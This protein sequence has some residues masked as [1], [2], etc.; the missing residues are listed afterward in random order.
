VLVVGLDNAGKTT[1][2]THLKPSKGDVTEVVPT[3]GFTVEEFGQNSLK[4][5]AFDMSGQSK[6][7]S[8]WEQY[9]QETQ[10]VIWVID[11]TDKFRIEVVKDELMGMLEHKH[12]KGRP[13]PILFF[14][15]KMDRAH[16]M[17][18]VV[19]VK[20]FSLETLKGISWYICASNAVSGEGVQDGINWLCEQLTGSGK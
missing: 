16:A 19:C 3:V 18:A 4:F 6:Y 10:A 5:H 14:A 13:V 9:Y 20:K 15:N 17:T 2:L 8:L 11:S 1:L 7:R 12:M